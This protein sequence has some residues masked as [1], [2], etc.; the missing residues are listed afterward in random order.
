MAVRRWKVSY[1]IAAVIILAVSALFLST[2]FLIPAFSR[3]FGEGVS[4]HSGLGK[5]GIEIAVQL[6]RLDV[7]SLA[8]TCLGIGIGFFALFSFF[9]V[10]DEA[11]RVS[12]EIAEKYFAARMSEIEERISDQVAT[13]IAAARKPLL[14]PAQAIEVDDRED[15]ERK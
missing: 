1:T 5:D 3:E 6:G 4:S 12:E 2:V 13:Q 10:K 8:I 11:E 15:R 9:A 7:V 14:K